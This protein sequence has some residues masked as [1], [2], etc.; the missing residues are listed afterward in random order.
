[1]IDK[2]GVKWL[3]ILELE[4]SRGD[5]QHS[6]NQYSIDKIMDK[7]DLLNGATDRKIALSVYSDIAPSVIA[8]WIRA[9]LVNG[10][11]MF[12]FLEEEDVLV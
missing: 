8:V 3:T 12:T 10:A 6:T 4:L 1:M 7:L 2:N 5:W 11:W 9:K